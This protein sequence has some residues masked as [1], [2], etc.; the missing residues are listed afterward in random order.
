[1]KVNHDNLLTI[2]NFITSSQ[3]QMSYIDL[4]SY[5]ISV[6]IYQDLYVNQYLVER[7]LN[8]HNKKYQ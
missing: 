5:C 4:I 1:M 7:V 8:E 3:E 6:G 2:L